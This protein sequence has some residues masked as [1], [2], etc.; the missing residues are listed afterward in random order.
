[1]SPM[2]GAAA[3]VLLILLAGALTIAVMRRITR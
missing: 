3:F 1:M 2:D